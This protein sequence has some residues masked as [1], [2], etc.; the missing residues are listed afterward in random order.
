MFLEIGIV[1]Y[2][3]HFNLSHFLSFIYSLC[4]YLFIH[5]FKNT[6]ICIIYIY[7]DIYKYIYLYIYIYVNIYIYML[8]YIYMYNIY[9]Y[10]CYIY[11]YMLISLAM[12][13]GYFLVK[14]IELPRHFA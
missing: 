10:I 13:M 4:N 8:I 6:Y 3:T 7:K 11:I 1:V 2:I 14:T 12:E 5:L 9:I